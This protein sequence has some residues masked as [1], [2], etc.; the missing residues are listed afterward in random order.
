ME[1]KTKTLEVKQREDGSW[2]LDTDLPMI[3]T[4][5]VNTL[6]EHMHEENM[7]NIPNIKELIHHHKVLQIG[8][9]F[10]FSVSALLFLILLWR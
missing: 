7:N 5:V 10:W 9:Y 6:L 4:E 1:I 2:F 8:N 3:P